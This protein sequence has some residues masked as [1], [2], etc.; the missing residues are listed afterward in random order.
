MNLDLDKF[1]PTIAEIQVMVA[2]HKTL[3]ITGIDDKE[4]YE[5]V[6][7]ARRELQKTRKS[8]TDDGKAMREEAIQFQK[9]VLA[10]EKEVLEMIVPTEKELEAKQEAIDTERERLKRVALLPERRD[11]LREF[12]VLGDICT[13]DDLLGMDIDAFEKFYNTSK[14]RYL[15]YQEEIIKKEREEEAEKVR[16]A[17]EKLAAEQKR[18]DA[19]RLALEQEKRI[20]EEKRQAEKVAQEKAIREAELAKIKAEEDKIAAV[21]AEKARIEAEIEA[22]KQAEIEAARQ[23][24]IKLAEEQ[25][26]LEKQKAYQN[27]LDLYD[28]KDDGT[29]KI[30]RTGNKVVLYKKL[31]ELI[32]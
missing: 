13:D 20:E 15:A 7:A 23:A 25:A 28:Y 16:I 22:T 9:A 14:Q 5:A 6:K 19:E 8:I 24:E 32:I 10:R 1:N 4:G 29:F 2:K 30:E 31:G 17:A 18:I 11:R 27:F 3:Q 12:T 26:A 21:A